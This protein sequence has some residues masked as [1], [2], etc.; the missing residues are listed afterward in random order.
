MHVAQIDLAAPGIRFKVSPGGGDRE[1]VRQTTL[2]F[3]KEQRAQLAI[4]G[5]FF[6]PFPSQDKT[7]W[8]IGLGVSEGRVF[9]AFEIPTQTYAL[10]PFAPAIN[11]DRAN[12]ASIVHYDPSQ[13]DQ[14][15]VIEKVELWNVLAGS[16]QIVTA[17]IASVP[18]YRDD[19]H[20]DAELDPGGPNDYSNAKAWADVRTARTAIGLSRDRRT[21]TLFTVDAGKSSE[22]MRLGE[23]A[24]VLIREFGVYDALNL[25]GGGSTT[26]AMEGADGTPAIV[27][28]SSDNPAGRS[29][30][31]SLAVFAQRRER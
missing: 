19:N 26:M 25:D 12:N 8:A 18:V 20:F 7:A 10:V 22:G 16:S 24:D 28:L 21:L 30:A 17:G 31:T 14:K 2:E 29:V 1:V 5:H 6:L 13:P 11:I 15:H 3:L 23:V 4:N 9:S 27:N